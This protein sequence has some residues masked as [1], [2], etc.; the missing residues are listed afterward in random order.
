M[1]EGMKLAHPLLHLGMK[2]PF[3]FLS[4]ARRHNRFW[5]RGGR[6]LPGRAH[7]HAGRLN[8]ET[9][10]L[11]FH[12]IAQRHF[13]AIPRV[14]PHDEGLNHITLQSGCDSTWIISVLFPSLFIFCFFRTGLGKIFRQHVHVARI[15]IEPTIQG[16][17]DVDHRHIELFHRHAGRTLPS[18]AQHRFTFSCIRHEEEAA[19]ILPHV[20]VHH[21]HIV[22][23]TG[24]LLHLR[25]MLSLL[26]K[27]LHQAMMLHLHLL[28]IVGA[29]F[30]GI[31]NHRLT[32][33][34]LGPARHRHRRRVPPMRSTPRLGSKQSRRR[35]QTPSHH[36]RLEHP[37]DT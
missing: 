23:C 3:K 14:C 5:V 13:Y 4:L 36:Y 11:A 7:N 1:A 27:L 19:S 32:L 10:I 25:I 6:R 31:L 22:E 21:R 8:E 20:L 33:Q 9:P 29:P 2:I 26:S 28:R 15:K 16:D 18:R 12:L 24:R 37:C 35:N 34:L 30:D 17:L